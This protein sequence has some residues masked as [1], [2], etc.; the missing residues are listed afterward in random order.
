MLGDMVTEHR[1]YIGQH[2][3]RIEL[4]LDRGRGHLVRSSRRDAPVA[5]SSGV[6]VGFG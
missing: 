1:D 3:R 5:T 2:R 4:V 6:N